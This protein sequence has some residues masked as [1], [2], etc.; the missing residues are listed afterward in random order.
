[1]NMFRLDNP[2]TFLILFVYQVMIPWLV[3]PIAGFLLFLSSRLRRDKPVADIICHI[4]L[5]IFLIAAM[6][7]FIVL[8]ADS[9]YSYLLYIAGTATLYSMIL[10]FEYKNKRLKKGLTAII[11]LLSF[12]VWMIAFYTEGADWDY[13][14]MLFWIFSNYVKYTISLSVAYIV[15][16][17]VN[18]FLSSEI[19]FKYERDMKLVAYALCVFLAGMLLIFHLF[20]QP[21]FRFSG[22]LNRYTGLSGRVPVLISQASQLEGTCQGT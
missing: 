6:N 18:K 7:I 20:L 11:V 8:S 19:L 12:L 3:V 4:L 10:P 16:K 22:R 14:G 15:A 1:M 2:D 21:D 9:I 5:M 17:L 13:V